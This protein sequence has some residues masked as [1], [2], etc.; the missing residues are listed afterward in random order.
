MGGNVQ[1]KRRTSEELFLSE[2]ININKV[3]LPKCPSTV[4]WGKK[5]WYKHTMNINQPKNFGPCYNMDTLKTL[6]R[7]EIKPVTKGQILYDSTCMS[8][9]QTSSS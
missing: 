1:W 9:K 3:I 6:Y 8:N 5:M 4:E 2:F 7:S